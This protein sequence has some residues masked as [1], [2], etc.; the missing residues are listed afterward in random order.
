MDSCLKHREISGGGRGLLTDC[1]KL[2]SRS[3][4]VLQLNSAYSREEILNI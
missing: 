2:N 4:F 1:L 3:L